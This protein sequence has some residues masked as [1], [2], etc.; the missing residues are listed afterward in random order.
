MTPTWGTGNALTDWKAAAKTCADKVQE[1]AP[2]WLIFVGGTNYNLEFRPFKTSPLVLN[3]P[4]K[5]VLTGH[6]YS[7]SYGN[8]DWWKKTSYEKWK[9]QFEN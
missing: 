4:N 5:L 6:L 9:E 8:D 2:H 7:W 1:I 3:I